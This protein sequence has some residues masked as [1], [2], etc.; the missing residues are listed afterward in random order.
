MFC[1]VAYR[2]FSVISCAGEQYWWLLLWWRVLRAVTVLWWY[3]CYCIFSH[4]LFTSTAWHMKKR[5]RWT[6][7]AA[8]LCRKLPYVYVLS[9]KSCL[10]KLFQMLF[11]DWFKIHNWNLWRNCSSPQQTSKQEH[12]QSEGETKGVK[13]LWKCDLHPPTPNHRLTCITCT[14]TQCDFLGKSENEAAKCIYI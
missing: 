12:G 8:V 3:R 9:Y 11:E 14:G 4:L 10:S 6:Q 5:K 13:L 7:T 2:C 1:S